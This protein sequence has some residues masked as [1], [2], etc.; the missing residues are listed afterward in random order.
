MTGIC[1]CAFKRMFV[2][3]EKVR[4]RAHVGITSKSIAENIRNKVPTRSGQCKL[5]H[6]SFKDIRKY[7]D[8]NK[9]STNVSMP[10]HPCAGVESAMKMSLHIFIHR[11]MQ[12][13][14]HMFEPMLI[15]KLIHTHTHMSEQLLTRTYTQPQ[16]VGSNTST[17]RSP[18]IHV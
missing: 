12:T 11:S 14:T 18:C 13:L 3:L 7:T 16:S 6:T 2:C 9:E 1:V 5:Q 4:A 15:Y 10:M 8:I 17:C